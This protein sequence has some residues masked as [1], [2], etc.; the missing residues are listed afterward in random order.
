MKF[1]TKIWILAGLTL[2]AILFSMIVGYNWGRNNTPYPETRFKT[3]TIYIKEPFIPEDIPKDTVKPKTVVI[4]QVDSSQLM[5]YQLRLIQDSVKY[6]L[7]IQGLRDSFLISEVFLKTYPSNPKLLGLN[8]YRDSLNLTTMTIDGVTKSEKY[9]LLLQD[10][11]YIWN[12]SG[13][14]YEKTKYKKEKR[15]TFSHYFGMQ[16]DF[17]N[18]QILP[19]Y[20]IRLN[21]KKLELN[22]SASQELMLNENPEIR[23]GINYKINK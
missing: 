21:I 22:L 6:S 18:K 13:L 12:I 10:Y 17:F 2:L 7:L 9:N 23:L 8:L 19:I 1:K 4:Y 15:N 11:N 14:G 20:Q 5:E 16:Y 3:D